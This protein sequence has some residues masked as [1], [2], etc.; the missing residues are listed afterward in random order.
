M[1]A[2]TGVD[3]TPALGAGPSPTPAQRRAIETPAGPVLVVAGPGTGKTFCLIGRIG[4]LIRVLGIPPARICAVTF[5]NKAADEIA[6]RL[7]R[8][9]HGF[10]GA[11]ARRWRSR[12]RRPPV[13]T[14]HGSEQQNQRKHHP[15]NGPGR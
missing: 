12:P 4:H 15:L 10:W 6:A 2:T 8:A 5:T 1:T 11:G 14:Q 7:R 13:L 3:A 9:R